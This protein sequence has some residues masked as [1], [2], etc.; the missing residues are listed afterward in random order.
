MRIIEKRVINETKYF[1]VQPD[2]VCAQIIE[3]T[4]EKNIIKNVTFH[5][6]CGGNTQGIAA[7]VKGMTI[8][9]VADKLQ[10]I[11]CGYKSTSCPD[12]LAQALKAITNYG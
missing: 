11:R 7:L 8:E 3:I 6:G 1:V 12:Q 5:G 10:G 4:I 2:G 9:E